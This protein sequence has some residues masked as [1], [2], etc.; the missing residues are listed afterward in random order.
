MADSRGVLRRFGSHGRLAQILHQE[1]AVG[2]SGRSV[3]RC[4]LREGRHRA[5]FHRNLVTNVRAGVEIPEL[6]QNA[7]IRPRSLGPGSS[8][9]HQAAEASLL[10]HISTVE[11]SQTWYGD[12]CRWAAHSPLAE[13]GMSVGLAPSIGAIPVLR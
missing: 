10:N 1:A 9:W 13:V 2:L 11:I 4:L 3:A 8:A 6:H 7:G 5:A 12:D